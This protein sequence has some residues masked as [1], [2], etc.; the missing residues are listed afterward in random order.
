MNYRYHCIFL[1]ITGC[2]TLFFMC[3]LKFRGIT[4]RLQFSDS[5]LLAITVPIL[6]NCFT[7]VFFGFLFVKFETRT[8]LPSLTPYQKVLMR[9]IS[10]AILFCIQ[11]PYLIFLTGSSTSRVCL[12][13]RTST[14]YKALDAKYLMR[15]WP[16]P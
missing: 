6:G 9:F 2:I 8:I 7:L 16:E 14:L 15:R 5:Q 4:P 10:G 3:Y 12:L 13:W 11:P 1:T